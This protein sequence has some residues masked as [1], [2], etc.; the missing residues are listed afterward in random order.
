MEYNDLLDYGD[1]IIR[2]PDGVTIEPKAEEVHGISLST[3]HSKGVLIGVAL[4][5]FEKLLL[6]CDMVVGHNVSFDKRMLMV[7]AIRNNRKQLFTVNGN[8]KDEFCTMK[9]SKDLC[10]IVA[11]NK[12]TGEQ[13]YKYPKLIELHGHLF[14]YMPTGLHDSLA[15]VLCCMRCF[16]KMKYDRDLIYDNRLFA[17]LWRQ[18]CIAM[19]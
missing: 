2:L 9:Q 10:K 8:R 15:D 1:Y 11:V 4:D 5:H 14:Q 12:S 19:T 13:Y 17:S 7:E 16:V 6:D 18:K 3:S